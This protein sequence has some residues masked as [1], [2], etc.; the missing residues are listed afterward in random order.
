M[1]SS[2][3]TRIDRGCRRTSAEG[4]LGARTEGVLQM[5]LISI[6]TPCYNEEENVEE[7]YLQIK[8][9]FAKVGH[10]DYEHIFIDNSSTDGT[11]RALKKMASKD[12]RLK[13]IVNARNFGQ[14]RSP[15]YALLQAR[16]NAA[17]V[18]SSDLQ[19]PPELIEEF[20]QR[21]ED[22][23]RIVMGVKTKS[24]EGIVLFALRTVY[25]KLLRMLSEA[26]LTSHLTG[27][28]LYD[29]AI[30]E[31]FR[32]MEE[33]YPYVRGML[34]EIGLGISEVEYKQPLRKRGRTKNNLFTLY[35]IAMLG[36]TSHSKV[37]LR[38][39]TMMGFMSS[40]ASLAVAIFYFIYKLI[41]WSSFSLGLAPV[42]VG[43]FFFASV[44]LTF[45][46]IVG[47][48]VGSIHTHVLKRPLV[49]ELERVNFDDES[50]Y[51]GNGA[52]AND[53]SRARP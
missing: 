34:A 29:R 22:G 45:L 3:Y 21:W 51:L 17:I 24:E 47:E 26:P 11:V 25:Y 12:K 40:I 20:L 14:V 44:Q 35:D 46:G 49:V 50:G 36:L 41:H 53:S 6:I 19:D 48:Y 15:Y 52:N 5:R 23:A 42:V 10:Y 33:P 28:G 31:I 43:L 4:E 13:I 9:V 30:I 16:G 1:V 39:M 32:G 7:V 27:F 8:E 38:L 37:P 2:P 18:L